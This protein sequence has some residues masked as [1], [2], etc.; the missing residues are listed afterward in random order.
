MFLDTNPSGN[1]EVLWKCDKCDGK[2]PGWSL[3]EDSCICLG[4]I[5][6]LTNHCD[7]C[8]AC[9]ILEEGHCVPD[10]EIECDGCSHLEEVE[11]VC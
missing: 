8:P 1:G 3:V 9:Y 2:A 4:E 6:P 7:A 11:G 5:D 10:P